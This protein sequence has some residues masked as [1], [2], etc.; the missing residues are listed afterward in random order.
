[1]APVLMPKDKTK[2]PPTPVNYRCPSDL[3]A[4]IDAA[5]KELGLS[6]NEAMTQLLRFALEQHQAERT[7]KPKK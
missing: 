6:R 5:A 4:S 2:T 3:L 1:M 7:K